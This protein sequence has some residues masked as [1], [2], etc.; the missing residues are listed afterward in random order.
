MLH[1]YVI[2]LILFL[3]AVSLKKKTFYS[4]KALVRPGPGM[5]VTIVSDKKNAVGSIGSYKIRVADSGR[6]TEAKT[7]AGLKLRP[8][9]RPPY[10]KR[11]P[12]SGG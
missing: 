4:G 12:K 5:S 9:V 1:V 3:A 6:F 11:P 10:D 2:A 8:T 7:A